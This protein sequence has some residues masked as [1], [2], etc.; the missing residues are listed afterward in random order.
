M[1]ESKEHGKRVHDIVYSCDDRQDLAER[2]VALE[3]FAAET[4]QLARDFYDCGG[5]IEDLMAMVA[6]AKE[7][8][9]PEVAE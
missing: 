2:I 1:A 4:C 6:E 9:L 8:G 3:D 5:T 7:L